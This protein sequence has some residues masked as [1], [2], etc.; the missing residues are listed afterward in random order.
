MTKICVVLPAYNEEENIGVLIEQIVQMAATIPHPVSIIV[1]D[2]G[3]ADGTVAKIQASPH[4]DRVRIV[5]HGRNQG[6]SRTLNTGFQAALSDPGAVDVL[7]TLDADNTHDPKY[8]PRMIDKILQGRDV[9]IA[10]R[11]AASGEEVGVPWLRQ[12]LSHGASLVFR[13]IFPMRN[14]RDYTCGYRA[15]RREILQKAYAHYGDRFIEAQGFGVMTEVLLKLRRFS[16]RCDE[17]GFV[18]RYDFKAGESKLRLGPTLLDYLAVIRHN[19]TA[20]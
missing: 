6:L 14:V 12:V 13:V 15:Y 16:V 20:S 3:S 4:Q 17:V 8:M 19:L 7:I 9:V 11:F 1:V 18:L 10:S 2:D 5:R